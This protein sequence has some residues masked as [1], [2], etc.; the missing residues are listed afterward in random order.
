MSFSMRIL[1]EYCKYRRALSTAFYAVY[2][3][4]GRRSSNLFGSDYFNVL[5]MKYALFSV[6]PKGAVSS[7]I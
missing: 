3:A 7:V 2:V 6:P 5:A 1:Q 4:S